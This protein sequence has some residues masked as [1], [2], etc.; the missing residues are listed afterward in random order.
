MKQSM[1]VWGIDEYE[2]DGVN[3]PIVPANLPVRKRLVLL[4]FRFGICPACVTM[5]L[6]YNLMRFVNRKLGA[7]RRSL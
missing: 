7:F 4:F 6:S 5:S 3:C 1:N 2:G